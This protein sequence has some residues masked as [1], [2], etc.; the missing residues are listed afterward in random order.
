MIHRGF[1]KGRFFLAGRCCELTRGFDPVGRTG[2]LN[3]IPH[4]LT[5]L[6]KNH[7]ATNE[8]LSLSH[9]PEKAQNRFMDPR[10]GPC[11][12]T[13]FTATDHPSLVTSR[14]TQLCNFGVFTHLALA[15][16]SFPWRW[17]LHPANHGSKVYGCLFLL[18]LGPNRPHLKKEQQKRWHQENKSS[19]VLQRFN[20]QL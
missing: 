11:I 12:N 6:K 17:V 2:F 1:S 15:I 16:K 13:S 3:R 4:V 19:T 5:N 10:H 20:I 8:D 7:I 18:T 9:A 14:P